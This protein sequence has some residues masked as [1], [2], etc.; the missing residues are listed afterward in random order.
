MVLVAPDEAQ[1]TQA[2]LLFSLPTVAR[3]TLPADQ[4]EH[5][6]KGAVVVH[7]ADPPRTLPPAVTGLSVSLPSSCS[8]ASFSLNL[9]PKHSI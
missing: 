4:R 7:P 5:Q 9:L 8:R 3:G 2:S 1:P 6:P